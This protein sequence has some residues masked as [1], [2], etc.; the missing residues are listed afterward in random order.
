MLLSIAVYATIKLTSRG[1]RTSLQPMERVW[2]VSRR[3]GMRWVRPGSGV[4][5]EMGKEKLC[6]GRRVSG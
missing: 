4:V 2:K 5:L 1:L 3:A 6:L